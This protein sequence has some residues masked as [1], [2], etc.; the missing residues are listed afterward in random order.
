MDKETKRP[1]GRNGGRIMEIKPGGKIDIENTKTPV[2]LQ[3]YRAAFLARRC[4]LS[5]GFAAVVA[6][7]LFGEAR[8]G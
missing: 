7:L 6:P 1:P 4:R 2:F 8:N 3:E 5:P